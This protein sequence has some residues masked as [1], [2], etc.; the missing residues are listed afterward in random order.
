M[1]YIKH[2]NPNMQ[3]GI[4]TSKKELFDLAKSWLILGIAFAIAMN[5]MRF[6]ATFLIALAISL[7][8]IGIGFILHELAHKFLA[9][10]Y[11]CFAEFRSYDRMLILAL[12]F[13]L[14]GFIFA[15]P[16]AVM[17]RG[18]ITRSQSGRISAAGPAMN[19]LVAIAFLGLTFTSIG[20]WRVIGL[21]G[22]TINSW[23]ALFNMIPFGVFDGKKVFDWSKPVYIGMAAIA[24][25]MVFGP[26][27]LL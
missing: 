6:D 18:H 15:A 17:I 11:G 4:S 7:T 16:G 3:R 24:L 21:Y 2:I 12:L 5:R 14:G 26:R 1:N 19:L 27:L 25:I 23:L 10:K 9:Q 22:F 20:I 8:T 13:S